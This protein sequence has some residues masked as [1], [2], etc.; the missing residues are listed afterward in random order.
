MIK[1]Y[2]IE[3]TITSDQTINEAAPTKL[4]G[5]IGAPWCAEKHSRNAYSGLIPISPNTT[6]SAPSTSSQSRDDDVE[7]CGA[8]MGGMT[9]GSRQQPQP[10]VPHRRHRPDLSMGCG[11]CAESR[12]EPQNAKSQKVC[13]TCGACGYPE[14]KHTRRTCPQDQLPP[15]RNAFRS[16]H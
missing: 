4:A 11:P 14:P 16:I 2:L 12:R 15:P 6:P 5:L 9:A 10:Q 8:L 3:T 7:E 13:R 1:R